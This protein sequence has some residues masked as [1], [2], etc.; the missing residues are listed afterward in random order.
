MTARDDFNKQV[1]E[2]LRIAFEG[3]WVILGIFVIV[4][5][6]TWFYTMQQDDV[7]QASATVRL[8]ASKD[9]LSG[10]AS[11]PGFDILGWGGERIIA[12]EILIIQSDAVADRVSR[13]LFDRSDMNGAMGDTLPILKASQRPSTLRKIARTLSLEGFF[14]SMGLAKLDTSTRMADQPTVAARARAQMSA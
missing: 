11:Q 5:A 10:Q 2:Y 13:M 3:K 8:K 7:F 9:L 4:V 12:N 14:V 1:Q 6:A